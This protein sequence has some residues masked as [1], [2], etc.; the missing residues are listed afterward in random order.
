MSVSAQPLINHSPRSS[1]FNLSPQIKEASAKLAEATAQVASL[2]KEVA[3][4][5]ESQKMH[6]EAM[7]SLGKVSKERD[8]AKTAQQVLPLTQHSTLPARPCHWS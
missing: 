1:A 7:E 5:T 3:S 6:V 2:E 4:L 8:A